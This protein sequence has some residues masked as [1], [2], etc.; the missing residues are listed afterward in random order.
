MADTATSSPTPVVV[1]T[2]NTTPGS[3]KTG[4]TDRLGKPW[5]FSDRGVAFLGVQESG[6]LNGINFQKHKVTE[7]LILEVYADGRGLLTVGLGHL[8]LPEDG[9]KLNDTVTLDRAR[10]WVK[11]DI[12]IAEKAVNSKVNVP[13]YQNE[14]DALVSLVFNCGI[15]HSQT[16][17]DFV[18]SGKYDDAPKMIEVYRI[19]HGNERRRKQEAAMFRDGNYDAA[20]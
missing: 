3:V 6:V 10:A 15:G 7:G 12:A 8:V 5:V 20:H 18:N 19:K 2:A 9:L 16:I 11:K 4:T 13:L 17:A 1:G 14:Y